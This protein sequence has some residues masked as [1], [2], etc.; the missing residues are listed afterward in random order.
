MIISDTCEGP[1]QFAGSAR[2]QTYLYRNKIEVVSLIVSR[3]EFN[4]AMY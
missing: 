3:A 1:E 2:E 4:Q